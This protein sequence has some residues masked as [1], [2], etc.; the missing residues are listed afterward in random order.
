MNKKLFVLLPA[1][2][3]MLAGCGE[4]SDDPTTNPTTE[5]TTSQPTTTTTTTT[6]Q[7]TTTTTSV[8]PEKKWVMLTEAPVVGVNYRAG[9]DH[10]GLGDKRMYLDGTNAGG[11]ERRF[12]LNEDESKAAVVTVEANGEGFNIKV[13]EKYIVGKKV[14]TYSNALFSDTAEG[15]PWLWDAEYTSFTNSVEGYVV[16]LGVGK[17]DTYPNVEAKGSV[18]AADMQHLHFY[19]EK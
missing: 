11:V 18:K 6:S 14:G 13:G 9:L 3:L 7:P 5:P 4:T 17:T 16:F 10:S 15:S 12:T 19:V 2:L 8:V 1:A